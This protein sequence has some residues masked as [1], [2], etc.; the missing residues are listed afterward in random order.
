MLMEFYHGMFGGFPTRCT[1]SHVCFN[2]F[3][4]A[5][6]HPIELTQN[7]TPLRE[8]LP[9]LTNKD[10]PQHMIHQPLFNHLF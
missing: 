2:Q 3:K 5:A 7:P 4:K 6:N 10:N 8:T 9:H 1:P